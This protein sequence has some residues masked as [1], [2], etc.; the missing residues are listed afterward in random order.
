M[1]SRLWNATLPVFFR[2]VDVSK[3]KSIIFFKSTSRNKSALLLIWN[4]T[5]LQ[6][7]VVSVQLV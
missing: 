5:L 4:D 6:C 1:D 2:L 3:I 7:N